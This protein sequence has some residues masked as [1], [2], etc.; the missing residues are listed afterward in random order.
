MKKF[1]QTLYD[2]NIEVNKV[3]GNA[4]FGSLTKTQVVRN[5]ILKCASG[6]SQGHTSETILI[7]LGLIT[8]KYKLTRK[9][10]FWLWELWHDT[11]L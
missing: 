9:G 7:E 5:G 2:F 6:Y 11:D 4:N 8:S 1:S 3:W 10:K